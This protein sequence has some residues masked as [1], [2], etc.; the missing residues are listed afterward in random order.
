MMS[1]VS[2][3]EHD[4]KK[5]VAPLTGVNMPPYVSPVRGASSGDDQQA[6]GDPVMCVDDGCWDRWPPAATWAV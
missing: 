3:S 2:V 5:P 6:G 1:V 4:T